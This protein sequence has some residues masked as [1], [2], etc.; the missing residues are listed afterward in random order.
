MP[1]VPLIP[2]SAP[3]TSEQRAWLNGFLAAW[4][5]RQETGAAVAAPPAAS[6]SS[7]L[8]LFGSQSG[9]AE[10]L[11]KKI[12]RLARAKNIEARVSSFE[13]AAPADL[14]QEP[15]VLVITSTWGEGEMPDNAKTYWEGINN[16]S[17]PNLKS[18]KFAVLALG[19]KNYGDTFCLAGR[20]FDERLEKLGAA[21]LQARLDCDVE[22]EAPAE[23]WIDEFLTKLESTAVATTP[24]QAITEP[25]T[26]NQEATASSTFSKKNP[27]PAP[28]LTNRELNG[29]GSAKDVRH[30]EFSLEGSGLN[31]ET[32]DALGVFPVN[33]SGF[34]SEILTASGLNGDEQV[35]LETI[36]STTVRKALTEH[37][38]L[39]PLLTAL[40]APGTSAG[41]LLEKLRPLQPRLYSISSSPR[42]HPG[43]VHLTVGAVRFELDGKP[44]KGACSTFLADRLALGEKARVFVQ[45]SHGFRL[46]SDGSLAIIMVGPGTGIAP[47]RAF[48]EERIATG[49]SGKNW[50][51]FGDQKSS[52]DYLYREQMEGYVQEGKLHRLDTAFSRDQ[53]EKIYVQDR[54]KEN[55]S[56]LWSWMQA[57]AHFYVCGDA[58]RMAKDVDAMLQ[59]IAQE[60]GGMSA[61]AA[62]EWTAALKKE[63]RYQRDVY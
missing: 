2:D 3:F 57:G 31:Y 6:G 7:L 28:F 40:P 42:A 33:C 21:R 23:V 56:E 59:Q 55:A 54:M 17:S 32:G 50:L 20:Q 45:T 61:E 4:L 36:G 46:P 24:V 49:A 10:G 37:L 9:N 44:R 41:A 5:A 18:T 53:A 1:T 19:D 30:L 58:K 35:E 52:T 8:V 11:A 39:R 27:F 12:G 25:R 13:S 51:F 22:F 43:Q 34:V 26:K 63:K 60:Q 16:G 29:K 14:A 15:H 47:F 38:E 62:K 48:I